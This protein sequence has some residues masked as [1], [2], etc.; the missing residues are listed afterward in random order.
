MPI[1]W[2]G[3]LSGPDEL[4]S[5]IQGESN[6]ASGQFGVAS[7]MY[8]RLQAGAAGGFSD[9][10]TGVVTP[11]N[12]NGYNSNPSPYAQQLANDLWGGNSPTGGS[13]GNALYFAAPAS[14]NA[15]WAN[16]NTASGRGLFANGTNL[17]G[18]YYSDQ[19]GPPSSAFQAP[20]FGGAA[21]TSPYAGGL[22]FSDIGGVPNIQNS[23]FDGLTDEDILGGGSASN[24]NSADQFSLFGNPS[25]PAGS[26]VGFN[27]TSP[28]SSGL[29]GGSSLFGGD[30]SSD[31]DGVT[32]NGTPV[33]QDSDF[34][35]LTDADI[36]GSS[37]ASGINAATGAGLVGTSGTSPTGAAGGAAIGSAGGIN[38]NLTDES[39]L[40]SSITSAGKAAQTGA[41]QAGS[42]VQTAAGGIAGTV[43]SIF[44][45]AQSYASGAIIIV[46]LVAIGL[47]FVAFGLGMFKHD[48]LTPQIA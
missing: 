35:G 21:G 8:N 12:F 27:A 41:T 45:N 11:S 6:S 38:V 43:A 48:S 47:I 3:V 30:A 15:A 46:A 7:V 31:T 20:S 40:P 34:D 39:G 26:T 14:N 9:S 16:P 44:N 10:I 28:G 13:T 22:D 37:G 1:Q 2:S 19:M 42:D 33:L 24:A 36:V 5:V 4:A 25:T 18:N 23:D 29:G 32:A 17:G